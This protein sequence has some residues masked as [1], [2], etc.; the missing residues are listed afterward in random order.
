MKKKKLIIVGIM[1][2]LV[3]VIGAMA[4]NQSPMLWSSIPELNGG[5]SMVVFFVVNKMI[6][7]DAQP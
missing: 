6:F 1:A 4:L 3:I 5:V 7:S 2:A